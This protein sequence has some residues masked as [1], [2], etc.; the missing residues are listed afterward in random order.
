MPVDR[1]IIAF[2]AVAAV[3]FAIVSTAAAESSS[4]IGIPLAM[5]GPLIFS[6]ALLHGRNG[7]V[8]PGMVRTRVTTVN[9]ISVTFLRD[10]RLVGTR[11]IR[12]LSGK[13]VLTTRVVAGD[14]RLHTVTAR[15]LFADGA[16]PASST[17]IH[18][19]RGCPMGAAA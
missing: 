12:T 1:H 9:A 8:A 4:P 19:F 16:R 17:L 7:C 14:A 2:L 10:G 18:R 5:P 13:V 6:S 3:L 11:A 15:V